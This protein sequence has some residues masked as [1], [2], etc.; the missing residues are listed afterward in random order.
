MIQ[1]AFMLLPLVVAPSTVP[2]GDTPPNVLLILVD[3]LGRVDLGGEGHGIHRT[4]NADRLRTESVQFANAYCNGPNC[5]PSRAALMTGRHG[6][7]T[8]IFTVGTAR[9]GAEADRRVEPPVNRTTLTEDEITLGAAMQAAGYQTGYLG[10]WHLGDDPTQQGFDRNVGGGRAGHPKSYFPPYRNAALED[11]PEGEYLVDRLAAETVSMIRDFESADAKSVSPWFVVWAP[12]AVHTPI[13]A[14]ESAAEEVKTRHPGLAAR[15][16]R[17]A[18][19]VEAVDRGIGTVLS[20][21]DLSNTLVILLSDNGGLN[22]ITDSAPWRG[23]KGMLY[24]GGIRTPLYVRGPD[25]TPGVVDAPV[26]AFDLYPTLLEVAGGDLPEGREID[27]VSFLP[28]LRGETL[29][30]GP[31]YWHFPA[32]LEGSDKES[33]E[34]DR[35]FRTTPC[36]A[37]RDGHWKLIEYFED[38]GVELF[39]LAR[40]S[41]EQR[42]L[43]ES[44]SDRAD[45]LRGRLE[46][47]REI[48]AAPLPTEKPTPAP[49]EA[50]ELEAAEES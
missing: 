25:F 48:V 29:D 32:Y 36:G 7:R 38:G 1:L 35:R 12:Y 20:G 6:A 16:A 11:G 50:T 21:V 8:G 10:K 46:K 42:N 4:P 18:A 44:E 34:P 40:D 39:N 31:L 49:G 37:I 5:A 19:M 24:E 33:R 47:W 27:G 43:A 26:Q 41:G 28:A 3:D 13:Q 17:Y 23:G 9:R 2:A 14:P 30:R 22:G 15:K 45:L